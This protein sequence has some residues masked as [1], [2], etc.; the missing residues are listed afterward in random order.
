[1]DGEN[2]YSPTNL[3]SFQLDDFRLAL[4][5]VALTDFT[6]RISLYFSLKFEPA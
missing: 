2:K 3:Y 1:M 5:L 6:L 4:A